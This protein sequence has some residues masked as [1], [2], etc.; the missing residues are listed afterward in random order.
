MSCPHEPTTLAWVYG[1]APDA[2]AILDEARGFDNAPAD[3]EAAASANRA[4]R[5]L[6]ENF[7]G[8]FS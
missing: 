2:D 4:R 7:I 6:R 5:H 8:A 3:L 1:E